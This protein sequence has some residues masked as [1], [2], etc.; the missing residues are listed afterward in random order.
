MKK[1]FI[2]MLSLLAVLSGCAGE[3]GEQTFA[4]RAPRETVQYGHPGTEFA[5]TQP[6]AQTEP[7]SGIQVSDAFADKA[8]MVDYD[9]TYYFHIPAIHIPGVNT[10]EV[11]DQMYNELYAFIDQYVYD[12]PDYPYLG[13]MGYCWGI[14]GGILSVIT[15]VVVAPDASPDPL[16][17]VYNVDLATGQR[18]FDGEVLAAFG[19]EEETYRQ[20]VR[21]RMEETFLSF[22]GQQE[23]DFYRQQYDKT[24]SDSNVSNA[25]AYID[26]SG[27]LAIVADIYSLAGGDS[28]RQLLCL[29][30]AQA[31]HPK[32]EP[33]E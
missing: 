28:Y 31:A 19:M 2:V 15:E 30:G 10:D 32:A 13:D 6:A 11:N 4:T 14:H 25:I 21:T 18:V 33:F 26:E 7:Q 23:G 3:A 27:E 12:N 5:P 22:F 29:S 16:Y 24:V 9:Q 8:V 1:L 17:V 20:Q